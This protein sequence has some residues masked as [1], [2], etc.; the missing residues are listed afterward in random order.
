MAATSMLQIHSIRVDEAE[1]WSNT[2]QS[3]AI[4]HN[5]NLWLKPA[6]N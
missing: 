6:N 3:K 4:A 2:I 1:G 5:L